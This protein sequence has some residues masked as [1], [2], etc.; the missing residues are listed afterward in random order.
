MNATPITGLIYVARG[1]VLLRLPGLR[2]F[3]IVPLLVNVGLFGVAIFYV[4]RQYNVFLSWLEDLLPNWLHWLEWILFPLFF[5]IAMFLV[6]LVSSMIANFLAAPF[7]ALLA[8]KVERHLTGRPLEGGSGIGEFLASVIPSLWNE[9]KKI[10]YFLGWAAVL[11]ILFVIPGI[12]VIAPFVWFLYSAWVIVV[13]YADIPMSNHGLS[14]KEGRFRLRQRR[15]MSLGFGATGLLLASVPLINFLAMPT[16][17][18]GAT[19]MWVEHFAS[20]TDMERN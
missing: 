6:F 17:V 8:E 13:E 12:N 2:A 18:A 15:M 20:D 7:N 19:I 1:M 11:M 16:C 9:V 3:V 5:L 10:T 4:Y 14:G